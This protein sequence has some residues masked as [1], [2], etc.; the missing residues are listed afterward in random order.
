MGRQLKLCEIARRRAELVNRAQERRMALSDNKLWT[1][2]P[3]VI[4][5]YLLDSGRGIG[6][7]NSVLKLAAAIL[8]VSF[9]NKTLR[10]A[11]RSLMIWMTFNSIRK[12]FLQ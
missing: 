10:L 11:S 1:S 3:F 12:K 4:V 2:R 8:A 7:G 5:E 6:V 9:P